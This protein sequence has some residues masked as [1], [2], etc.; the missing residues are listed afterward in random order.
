MDEC[1]DEVEYLEMGKIEGRLEICLGLS[2]CRASW[3]FDFFFIS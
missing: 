2:G 3:L 1:V